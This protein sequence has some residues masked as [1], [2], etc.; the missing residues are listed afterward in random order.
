MNDEYERVRAALE[1]R[2]FWAVVVNPEMVESVPEVGRDSF[3]DVWVADV[4]LFV[5]DSSVIYPKILFFEHDNG[6]FNSDVKVVNICGIESESGRPH[7]LQEI[8]AD[9]QQSFIERLRAIT[10]DTLG[11]L[12]VLFDGADYKAEARVTAAFIEARGERL[13]MAIGRKSASSGEYE[14]FVVDPVEDGWIIVE[15]P[16]PQPGLEA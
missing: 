16:D 15:N 9:M 8:Y 12:S 3:F 11:P 7:Q 5:G 13:L 4:H 14:L 6:G 10:K 1:S 2:Q